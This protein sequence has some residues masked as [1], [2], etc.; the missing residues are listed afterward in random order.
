MIIVNELSEEIY[1]KYLS[2]EIEK[3][4]KTAKGLEKMIDEKDPDKD[5]E[6]IDS[7]KN[8]R[9]TTI[10][11]IAN[12]QRELEQLYTKIMSENNN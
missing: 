2:E 4:Q 3:M 9:L 7:L 10:N 8:I 6:L 1:I 11:S 12:K 5:Y